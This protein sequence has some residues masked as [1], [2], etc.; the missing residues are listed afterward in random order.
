MLYV[1]CS[2]QEYSAVVQILATCVLQDDEE[3]ENA[4]EALVSAG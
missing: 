1:K 4:A 3:E 2:K